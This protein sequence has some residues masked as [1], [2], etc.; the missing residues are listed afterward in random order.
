MEPNTARILPTG[1]YF[2]RG[3]IYLA[4]RDDNGT[5]HQFATGYSQ[6]TPKLPQALESFRRSKDRELANAIKTGAS[7]VPKGITVSDLFDLYIKDI[8]KREEKSAYKSDDRTSRT[9]YKTRSSVNRHLVPFFGEMHPK[10][11]DN[12]LLDE[13]SAKRMLDPG[14]KD[15]VPSTPE[16]KLS[17]QISINRELGYLRRSMR[18]GVRRDYVTVEHMA[19]LDFPIDQDAEKLAAKTGTISEENFAKLYEAAVPHF[20]PILVTVM[21]TGVRKKE[22]TWVRPE[23]VDFTEQVIHLRKGETKE[24]DPR[25]VPMSDFVAAEL[26]KWAE[27]TAKKCPE[28]GW[29]FH[30]GGGKRC[31]NFSSAWESAVEKAG[32][33]G[34]GLRFHDSRR[35]VVTTLMDNGA[36]MDDIRKVTG[37]KSIAYRRYD[38]STR[39]SLDRVRDVQNR[40][41]G[42]GAMA[43]TMPP[44]EDRA[45]VVDWSP[46]DRAKVV[47]WKAELKELKA[48]L[49]DGTF[50]PEEFA[51]EKQRVMAS[52]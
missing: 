29:F 4:I 6:K 37:H 36:Q 41:Q 9:S 39:G 22:I 35:T 32:L 5:K 28:A 49:D 15:R 20:K 25:T 3:Y 27:F 1:F 45:K 19:K 14:R 47:D 24:S 51:A 38:Q 31:K 13:Y 34:Q 7:K 10:N 8:E 42:S 44:T 46:S 50:T 26:K 12:K 43:A 23:Q 21:Y 16:E 2:K 40:T 30:D 18:L 52:R 33:K 48:M 11:I 17:R